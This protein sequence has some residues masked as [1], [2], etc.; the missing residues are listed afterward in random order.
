MNSTIAVAYL[1]RPVPVDRDAPGWE[2][3][4]YLAHE[5]K[6][7]GRVWRIVVLVGAVGLVGLTI[8]ALQIW[9]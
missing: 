7:M 6:K 2:D 4:Y 8:G 9:A 5:P 3:R 1:V